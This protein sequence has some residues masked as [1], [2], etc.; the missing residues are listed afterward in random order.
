MSGIFIFRILRDIVLPL[1][2][3][4]LFIE[5]FILKRF[6][7]LQNQSLTVRLLIQNVMN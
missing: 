3:L 6:A 5:T 2:A 1:T 4:H 7:S